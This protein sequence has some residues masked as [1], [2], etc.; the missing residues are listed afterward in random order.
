M[1]DHFSG[2]RASADPAADICDV[3]VFPSPER[4]ERLVM[5]MDLFPFASSSALFSDAVICRFRVRPVTIPANGP[6]A[7]F[8]V[9]EQ[10]L[11]FDCTFD[12]PVKQGGGE[13]LIQRATCTK[14]NGKSGSAVVNNEEGGTADGMRFYAGVR[15]DPFI[16]C[17]NAIIR[18]F[19]TQRLSFQDKGTNNLLG[20]NVLSLVI[21]VDRDSLPGHGPLFAVVGETLALGKPPRR[22]E[23][24][25]RP[26]MKNI[27]LSYG[28]F[29][30]INPNL[31][32]REIYN[33]DDAFELNKTNLEAYRARFN[34]NLAFFDGLDGKTDWPLD[35]CG[36]HPL[37]ELLLHDFLVVDVSNPFAGDSYLEIETAMLEGRAHSTCGGRSL[38]ED[39]MDKYYTVL[40]NAG[41]GP[42]I[43][44][45]VDEPTT[46]ASSV[47]PYLAP[48]NVPGTPLRMPGN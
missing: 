46:L 18:T 5:V 32:I 24:V 13:T 1:S 9:G 23:R 10:E 45:G 25:G 33:D 40:I 35:R 16:L 41:R 26:E 19:A 8:A 21:E 31:E 28:A 29:D 39:V 3:Y 42:R 37:T 17:G 4:E 48:A 20:A 2:P 27:T 47:F 43:R 11:A 34:A 36:N 44:D 12:A 14:P 15:S 6:T 30:K 22:I 38:N 7:A